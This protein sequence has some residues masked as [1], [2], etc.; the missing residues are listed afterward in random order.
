MS[1][2]V[3]LVVDISVNVMMTR[4]VI[5]PATGFTFGVIG[6]RGPGRLQVRSTP[7]SRHVAKK[8]AA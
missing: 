3:V 5:V 2:V 6:C 1:L 4:S 8:D 7:G